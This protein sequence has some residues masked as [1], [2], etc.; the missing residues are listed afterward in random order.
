[1][2]HSAADTDP[3]QQL[4]VKLVEVAEVL[5]GFMKTKIH[6]E[7]RKNSHC[8]W[9]YPLWIMAS[10]VGVGFGC[11]AFSALYAAPGAREILPGLCRAMCGL[12]S[13]AEAPIINP[14]ST[15]PAAEFSNRWRVPQPE[16]LTPMLQWLGPL[17]D[18]DPDLETTIEMDA[19]L[20]EDMSTL[21]LYTNLL[22]RKLREREWL[23]REK[24]HLANYFHEE[25]GPMFERMHLH[26]KKLQECQEKID[27]MHESNMEKMYADFEQMVRMIEDQIREAHGGKD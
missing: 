19:M 15:P 2:Q 9:H 25:A 21:S 1:M 3:R 16:F 20:W 4:L 7:R 23:A 13:S 6:A 14:S 11:S 10:G 22:Q 17:L 24:K 8:W 18:P 26:Q 27:Q 5:R 12:D